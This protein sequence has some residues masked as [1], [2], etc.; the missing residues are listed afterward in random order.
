[1]DEFKVQTAS[2]DASVGYTSGAVINMSV[3]PG[4]NDFH[5]TAYY[6]SIRPELNANQW[7]ANRAGQPRTE[8]KYHRW[9][10]SATGPV[11]L[12][13]IY[14]GRERTFFSMA[15]KDIMTLRRGRRR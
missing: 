13:R 1:M 2:F 15:T 9:G 4:T 12:P 14:S 8:F 3:K 7:F 11:L 6:F 10:G 5:G